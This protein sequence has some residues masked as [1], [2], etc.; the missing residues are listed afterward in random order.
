MKNLVVFA[1]GSGS[2]FKNILSAI[3]DGKLKAK[4]VGFV[5]N[6]PESGSVLIAQEHKIPRFVFDLKQKFETGDLDQA[7]LSQLKYWNTDYIILAGYL[8]KIP[9]IIVDAFPNKILNIHPS[10]LPKYGGKGFYG[11]KVHEAVKLNNETETGCTIHLV[12]NEFDEGPILRQSKVIVSPNDSASQIAE[13]V[14][15]QEHLSYPEVIEEFIN[16]K[17]K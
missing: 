5:S 1:S 15:E 2:N 10:L 13:K 4:V 8:L 9:E 14:L 12:N 6:K 11:M 16:S 7:I 3:S 17:P